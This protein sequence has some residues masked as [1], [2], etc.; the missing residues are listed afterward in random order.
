MI[1]MAVTLAKLHTMPIGTVLQKGKRKR[2]YLG[3]QG[4]FVFYRTP[5]NKDVTGENL[6]DF[7]KWLL[8]AEVVSA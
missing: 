5:S 1:I 8:D 4:Y 3:M 6:G 2:I 7:R